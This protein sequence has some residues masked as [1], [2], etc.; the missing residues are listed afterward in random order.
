MFRL[1]TAPAS[2]PGRA[3]RRLLRLLA[4]GLLVQACAASAAPGVAAQ[5]RL[6]AAA[7]HTRTGEYA[8]ARAYLD[9]LVSSPW[10]TGRQ[11]ARAFYLRG[12]GYAR[13]DMH[14]SALQDFRRAIEFHPNHAASLVALADLYE[15]GLGV[16]RNSHEAFRL[17]LKA[18]RGGDASA[19]LF[20][21]IA[22]QDGRGTA[23]NPSAARYWLREAAVGHGLTEAYAPYARS[24]RRGQTEEPEPQVALAWYGRAEEEG[25]EDATLAI[26]FMLRDGELG[27]ADAAAAAAR[28]RELAERGHAVAQSALAHL[29]LG[30]SGLAADHGEAMRLYTLAAE[31]GEASAYA[32]LAHLHRHG[33]G[34]RPD[35]ARAEQWLRRA[36]AAGHGDSQFRLARLIQVRGDENS[37]AE[38]LGWLYA[39]AGAG[40]EE[41]GHT[42]AWILAT[43]RHDA[44]R[45]P[46][47]A[48]SLA[49]A[50]VSHRRDADTLDT[51]AAAL[52]A[53]GDFDEAVATQRLAL[54]HAAGDREL[55]A[56]LEAYEGGVAWVE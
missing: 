37:A 45:D 26:A 30:G 27:E 46:P 29:Y 42:A 3:R 54:D 19:A 22:M 39:A 5:E 10:I 38:A 1:P 43:T 4:G 55:L 25:D 9:S 48:V 18:A 2:P 12:Y 7:A 24:F 28:F 23:A 35:A 32:G 15:R 11:R 21:G 50:A 8:L 41:A 13:T 44:L 40:V 53:A 49:R 17:A 6:E 20:V 33:L 36:A 51:L 14:V 31:G 16:A 34:T 52:A 56:H 47:R